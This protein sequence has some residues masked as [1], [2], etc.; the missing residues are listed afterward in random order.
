MSKSILA[1]VGSPRKSGLTASLLKYFKEYV[2]ET[3]KDL[4]VNLIYL[5]DYTIN[6]CN[7][8][9]GCLRKPNVC[10]QNDK[11]DMP[12]I[13]DAMKK[14]DAIVIGAPSYFASVPG[15]LKD[16]I[17]RSRAMK[18]AKYS[19]KD[20]YFSVITAAGLQGGGINSVQDDLIHFALIQGMIVV[21]ALGHP[22]LVGNLPSETLQKLNV[23]DFRKPSEPGEVS[24]NGVKSLADR[25][26]S[27]L[28]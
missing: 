19:I 22:V 2:N 20:K 17:D 10:S 4:E 11:D 13:E 7:G 27:L 5:S 26:I 6:H 1:I 18:M 23:K 24:K 3:E 9:D 25:F 14:A 15:I 21:G 12:K 28:K 8:C 16:I